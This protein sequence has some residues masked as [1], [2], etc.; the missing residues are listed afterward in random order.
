MRKRVRRTILV[1]LIPLAAIAANV[2]YDFY[3]V[4]EMVRLHSQPDPPAASPLARSPD[5]LRVLFIGNSF[6][7]FYGGQALLLTR[8]AVSAHEAH[9]PIAEQ[10]TVNGVTLKYHWEHGQALRRIREGNWDYVVLQDHS[11]NPI[12]NRAEMFQYARLF[13]AEIRKVGAR[14]V[15]YMTWARKD[16][17]PNQKVIAS[18]YESLA[19]EL[20]AE[21]VPVGLAWQDS[22]QESPKL[23]LFEK[24]KKHPNSRG[25]YL[26]ACSFYRFFYGHSPRGLEHVVPGAVGMKRNYLTTSDTDAAFLQG[27]AD[28]TVTTFARYHPATNPAMTPD[29]ALHESAQRTRGEP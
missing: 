21:V 28:K 25:A 5:Y 11:T 4:H 10:V 7:N 17:P 2:G 12:V 14:T 29:V 16:Q 3:Q 20:G 27:V 1:L 22:I 13:D 23:E 15:F 18:A 24:D 9:L 6:T 8:L 19:Q 26:T